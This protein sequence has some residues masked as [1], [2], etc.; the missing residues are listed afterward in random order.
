MISPDYV[1]AMG[2]P[3]FKL[4][5]PVRLQLTCVGSKSMINYGAKSSTVFGNKNIE[6]Y[7]DVANINHY[8]VM[9]GMP[10]LRWLGITLDFTGQGAI[11]MGMYI[12]PMNM[13]SESSNDMQRTVSRDWEA[14]EATAKTP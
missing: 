5:H 2:I 1:W 8:D 10:F 12:V 4:E 13:P 3:I 7:F 14:T 11:C 9:L 6:E